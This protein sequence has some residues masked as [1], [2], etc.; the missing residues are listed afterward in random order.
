MLEDSSTY[1]WQILK[2][3]FGNLQPLPVVNKKVKKAM[4]NAPNGTLLNLRQNFILQFSLIYHF[5]SIGNTKKDTL[6]TA[7]FTKIMMHARTHARTHN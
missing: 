1:K 7:I 4:R 5:N 3:K 6:E 2:G